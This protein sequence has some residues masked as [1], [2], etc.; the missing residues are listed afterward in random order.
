LTKPATRALGKAD[1][2]SSRLTF[3]GMAFNTLSKRFSFVYIAAAD[4]LCPSKSFR[5]EKHKQKKY[6]KALEWQNLKKEN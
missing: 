2:H 1:I 4:P 5:Q 3:G 6:H